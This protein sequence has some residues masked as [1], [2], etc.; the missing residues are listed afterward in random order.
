MKMEDLREAY[1]KELL[2]VARMDERV[3]ALDADLCGS[4]M[5]IFLEKEMPERFFEMGIAEQNMVSV[6]AGLSLAGK[7]PFINSFSVFAA[8]QPYNQIR[9]GVALPNL[10]IRI[11]GSSCGLSDAG[12]GAT[13]QSVEDIA[14]MRAIP[15]MTVIV[16]ADA[17]ETRQAVR[18]SLRHQGPIYIRITRSS[19]PILTSHHTVFEI[20]K[21]YCLAEGSDITI[22]ATGIMGFQALQAH[23]IL[24]EKGIS[25]RVVNVST[26]KPLHLEEVL[27]HIKGV[28]GIVTAE[29]HSII[30][31]LGSAIAETLC[32]RMIP[33]KMI[34]IKD[35]F[36]QSARTHEELL[37][38][39]GL[40]PQAIIKEVETLLE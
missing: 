16:P 1:G 34:G 3:V 40:T 22:F 28:K 4:T 33:I 23:E 27:K 17:D 19:L 18:A 14:I 36:G 8:G 39:Y 2:A 20:G 13:H 25:V 6:A 10:N 35:Q 38:Y 15:N 30:G 21:M 29:E 7:I 26:I 11:V 32:D 31:G 37:E 5:T 9:Q 12:D 24:R